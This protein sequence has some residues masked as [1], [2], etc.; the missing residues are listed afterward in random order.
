MTKP[1]DKLKELGLELP[2]GARP[3]G[4]YVP[5]VRTGNLVHV[6]GQLPLKN[7]KLAYEGRVGE[8]L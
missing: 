2:P 3:L 4:S 1:S 8:D 5:A 7:G 6:S